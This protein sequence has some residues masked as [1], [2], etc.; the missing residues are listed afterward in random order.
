MI[1]WALGAVAFGAAVLGLITY[2]VRQA[3]LH[4]GI[5]EDLEDEDVQP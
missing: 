3:E 5:A 2:G 4:A 1:W